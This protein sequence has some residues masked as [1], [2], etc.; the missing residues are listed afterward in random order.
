M[1]THSSQSRGHIQSTLFVK[2]NYDQV[3][4]NSNKL[5][6]SIFQVISKI[7]SESDVHCPGIDVRHGVETFINFIGI[8]TCLCQIDW[9][10]PRVLLPSSQTPKSE[11]ILSDD[12]SFLSNQNSVLLDSIP[13]SSFNPIPADHIT[14][15]YDQSCLGGTFDRLHAGHKILL[16]EA[17]LVANQRAVIGLAFGDLLN[18]KLLRELILPFDERKCELETFLEQR[19]AT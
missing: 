10:Y 1:K 3:I 5:S 7:Y 12:S 18:Q 13:N 14:S 2:P 9:P 19:S 16:S 11:I 17:L 6:K 8:N 15:R 4:F